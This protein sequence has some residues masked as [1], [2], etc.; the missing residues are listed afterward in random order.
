MVS[1]SLEV[2]ISRL[3]KDEDILDNGQLSQIIEVMQTEKIRLHS[4]ILPLRHRNLQEDLLEIDKLDRHAGN[5]M[6]VK[7]GFPDEPFRKMRD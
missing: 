4:K 7:N 5:L 3:K 2:A 6:E 1:Q